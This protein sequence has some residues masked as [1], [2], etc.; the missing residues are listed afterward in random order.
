MKEKQ[1]KILEIT[2]LK[3]MLKKSGELYGKEAA[4]KLKTE[5]PGEYKIIT[6]REA[7]DNVDYL[8]TA[9]IKMGLKGKRIAVIGENRYEWG[10]SY[11]AV[12]CGTGIVVPLDK[13]L[14]ENELESLIVR[15]NVEAIIFT[16]KYTEILK[17]IKKQGLG[18][19]KKLISMDLAENEDGIYSLKLLVEKGKKLVEEGNREFIDAKIDAE[20]MGIMLFTSGTTAMS[21]AVML[22]HKNI[23]SNIMAIAK[24]LKLYKEDVILSFLPLHHVFECTAGF[25]YPLYS[26]TCVAYCDGI[27]HIQS[28]LQEYHVTVLISVPILF[29]TMYRRLMK[30]IEKKGKMETL[31]KGI[32]ISQTLLKVHIDARRKIFKEIHEQLGGKV[33]LFISGAA[34]L[35]VEVER[36]YNALGIKIAQGYGLTET[37]PVVAA[38]SDF[39]Y[40]EG[41]IGKTLPGISAKIHKPDEE[42]VGELVVKG[43]NVMLG[44]YE[45]EEET[46]K[47]LK[48]GWFHTGDLARIDKDGYI[49]ISGRKKSVIVLK[50]GK[51]VFPEEIENLINRIEGVKDSFV[52]GKP[53]DGDEKDPT[54]CVE[55][56]YEPEVME[57]MYKITD[58]EEMYKFFSGKIKEINKTMPAYKYIREINLTTE[59]LI[60]TTTAKIK[61]HE[62]IKKVLGKKQ[63]RKI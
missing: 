54:V 12:A 49:F 15:S 46:K 59:E 38:G 56:V 5:I 19:L 24:S 10:L 36:G 41:A 42:G 63:S 16:K 2:D 51:N 62:E 22:S 34:A 1:H 13:S 48:D 25:L 26:G 7:R 50:N 47:V 17:N 58:T 31:Q 40:R 37:S 44:Y 60:K 20:S 11:L 30:A 32:K 61:R 3:D 43:P 55:I 21:K 35:D 39:F 45:N 29:E 33:R 53:E 8:G 9:L 52:Y 14:P 4:Y 23:C 18:N 27:K 6:H 28:N 57:E